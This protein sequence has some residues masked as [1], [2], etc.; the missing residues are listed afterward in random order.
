MTKAILKI[1]DENSCLAAIEAANEMVRVNKGE[2]GS[3]KT[4]DIAIPIFIRHIDH[5]ND[6][7]MWS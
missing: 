6:A 3:W 2:S 7:V 5:D 1:F 4:N